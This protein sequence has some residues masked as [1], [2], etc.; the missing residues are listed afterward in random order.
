MR[1]VKLHDQTHEKTVTFVSLGIV[2]D[3]LVDDDFAAG[4]QRLEGLV[5]DQMLDFIAPVV[6][7]LA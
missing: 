2:H 7:D 3:V 6:K 4:F 1:G 5:Q